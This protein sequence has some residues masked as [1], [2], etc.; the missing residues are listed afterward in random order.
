MNRASVAPSEPTFLRARA[1]QQLQGPFTTATFCASV[2]RSNLQKVP[3]AVVGCLA[4]AVSNTPQWL[5]SSWRNCL[6]IQNGSQ[7][8]ATQAAKMGRRSP[9]QPTLG[10]KEVRSRG[11]QLFSKQFLEGEF[12]EVRGGTLPSLCLSAP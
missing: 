3:R 2:F 6:E 5:K 9:Y 10:A 12:C 1:F 8:G 4:V 11:L 7:I